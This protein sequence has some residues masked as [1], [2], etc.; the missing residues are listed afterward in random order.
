VA[1]T[2]NLAI[3]VVEDKI[4]EGQNGQTPTEVEHVNTLRA[5]AD[6]KAFGSSVAVNPSKGTKVDGSYT[7]TLPTETRNK[8]NV[9]VVAVLWKMDPATGEPTDVLNSNTY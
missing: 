3:Y 4:M 6:G 9:K 5:I 1:G 2:Y 8:D 7:V